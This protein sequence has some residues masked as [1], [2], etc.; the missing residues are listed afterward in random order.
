MSSPLGLAGCSRL[1]PS[2]N[3]DDD[4]N[5]DHNDENDIDIKLQTKHDINSRSFQLRLALELGQGQLKTGVSKVIFT[6]CY[7]HHR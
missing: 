7:P 3:D 4:S 6:F 2:D 5:D 1:W